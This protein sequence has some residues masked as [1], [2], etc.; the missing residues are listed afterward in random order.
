M[1]RKKPEGWRNK[2]PDDPFRHSQAAR[3]IKTTRQTLMEVKRVLEVENADEF[4]IAAVEDTLDIID[5]LEATLEAR[6]VVAMQTT[7]NFWPK[8]YVIDGKEF[9]LSSID[10]SRMVADGIARGVREGRI[11]DREGQMSKSV[12]RVV[13]NRKSLQRPYRARNVGGYSDGQWALY[14]RK[15]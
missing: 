15:K 14:E 3:G 6:G 13:F 4:R 1:A 2:K 11:Y 9:V 12:V 8:K 5:E 10:Q 7:G